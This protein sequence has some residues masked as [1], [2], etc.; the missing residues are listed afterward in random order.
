MSMLKM[1][2]SFFKDAIKYKRE[3]KEQSKWIDKYAKIKNYSVN[4]NPMVSTNLKIWLTEMSEIYGQRLCPCFDPSGDKDRDREMLCPC[5]YVDKE[6]EEYGTCHC[7]LFGSKELSKKEWKESASRLMDEYRVKL[8]IK[9]DTL[10]TRGMPMDKFR[11]LPI[12]DASHQLKTALLTYKKDSI[13]VIVAT[14]Q[15]S[16][17][18]KKIAE[19][20]GYKFDSKSDSNHFEITLKVK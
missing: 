10:D 4:P 15:E 3:I 6:I 14:E 5:K 1:M 17:N 12:P 2:I 18:L 9:E 7:A 16:L 8:D 19:F 13:K 20:K 11:D